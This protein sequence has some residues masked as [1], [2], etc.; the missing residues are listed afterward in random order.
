MNKF[1]VCVGTLLLTT[2][3]PVMAMAQSTSDADQIARATSALPFALRAGATVIRYDGKGMPHVLRQGNNHIFCTDDSTPERF[4]ANCRSDAMRPAADLQALEKAQG[5]DN[6][7]ILAD[8][9]AAYAS[10]KLKLL[11]V[12]TMSYERSGKTE[13]DA[14][15]LWRMWMPNVKGEELGLPTSRVNSSSPWMM[16]SGKVYAHVMLPQSASMDDKPPAPR[17]AR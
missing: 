15:S 11:P 1:A 6:K 5:K 13:A 9:D 14:R 3:C 10:G 17:P 7:T 16:F 4:D 8:Q 2:G 12:G